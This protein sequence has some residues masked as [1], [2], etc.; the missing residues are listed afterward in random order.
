MSQMTTARIADPV[1]TQVARGYK[2]AA[3]VGNALFPVVPVG[4]RGGN[5][6]E[7]GKESF[8]LYNTAR[9]PG[10]RVA[11]AQ[12]GYV[13]KPYAL[14][15]HSIN[16]LVPIEHLQEAANQAPG[17]NLGTGAVN[18]ARDIILKRLEIDQAAIARTAAS[19]AASNKTTLS[20]TSQWSDY[21]GTSDPISNVDDYKDAIRAKVGLM[22]NTILLPAAVFKKLRNHPKILDRIKYT[23]RESATPEILAGLFEIENVVVGNSIYLDADGNMQDVWGKDVVLAYTDT[24]PV[25]NM[26]SP[27]YGYTYQLSGYPVSEATYYDGDIRSWLYPCTDS[28]APVIAGADAG[29]LVVN[30][31]V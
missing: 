26:G 27:S 2:N 21:S 29:F 9:A 10:S 23:G 13:G 14:T 15:D 16:G 25:A 17:I 4:L 28:V 30:A 18:F 22:P 8:R 5:I 20:G 11:V 7:F 24:S 19:Y 1:L 12:F 31:V 6:I 3:Y